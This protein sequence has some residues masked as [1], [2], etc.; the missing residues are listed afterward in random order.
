MDDERQRL[1]VAK[2]V[3]NL[4]EEC[5]TVVPGIQGLFGFQLIAVFNSTFE[6]K[7][8]AWEQV[9]HVS[10]I[11]LVVVSL[12]CIMTPAA[13]HRMTGP[14]EATTRFIVISTRLLLASMSMLAI[15]ITLDTFLVSRLVFGLRGAL[16]VGVALLLLFGVLWYALP[17]AVRRR[18]HAREAG[19]QL[20]GSQDAW[21]TS[22]SS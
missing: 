10:A 22:S 1:T 17:L 15:A 14:R 7:L 21:P 18:Q 11:L 3:E 13:Y 8:A 9:L 16:A 20:Q 2:A 12:A 4:L 19:L 6:E 5:R